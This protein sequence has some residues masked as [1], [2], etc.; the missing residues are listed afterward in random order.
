[1]NKDDKLEIVAK[2]CT[3]TF[4]GMVA[5]LL[6]KSLL[7]GLAIILLTYLAFNAMLCYLETGTLNK[8]KY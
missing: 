5:M 3:A 6:S 1:M 8:R 2:N 7:I 4:A